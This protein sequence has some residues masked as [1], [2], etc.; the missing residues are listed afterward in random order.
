MSHARQ[1]D[2]HLKATLP[3]PRE[4]TPASPRGAVYG[5]A[6][7]RRDTRASAGQ[8]SMVEMAGPRAEACAHE[9]SRDGAFTR[10]LMQ[11]RHKSNVSRRL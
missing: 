11:D 1:V 8:R 6:H 7:Y 10:A 9:T 3:R 4:S 2:A 5:V